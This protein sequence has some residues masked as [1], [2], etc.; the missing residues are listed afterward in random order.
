[1][2]HD[3]RRSEMADDAAPVVEDEGLPTMDDAPGGAVMGEPPTAGG[4]ADENEFAARA[5]DA[6]VMGGAESLVMSEPA[7]VPQ[8]SAAGGTEEQAYPDME[9]R[10]ERGVSQ[11]SDF[12]ATSHG[13]G[14]LRLVMEV[15]GGGM[16][17]R[18][19]SVND[20]PLMEPDLT[21]E[22]AYEAVVRGRRVGAGGLRDLSRRHA[23]APP[24]ADTAAHRVSEVDE[25]EFVVRI[26]RSDIT[27]DELPELVVELSR[28]EATTELA[29]ETAAM[30]GALFADAAVAAGREPPTVVARLEGLA[31]H[32][33]PGTAAEQLRQRLR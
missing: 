7:P 2:E 31:L 21:G 32:E 11:A 29:E 13:E 1:M 10:D 24:E 28:P 27:L 15:S 26:P 16:Q 23:Y 17:V 8:P 9:P 5:D 14:Y 18:D 33:L 3:E 20:G 30:P 6:A 4:A 12:A 22:M 25:Y 19:A